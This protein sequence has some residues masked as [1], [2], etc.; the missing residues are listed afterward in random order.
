[1][2]EKIIFLDF[3]GPLTNARVILG[4]GD[5]YGFDPVA[6]QAPNNICATTGIRI[7][8]SSSRTH[9]SSESN[10]QETMALFASHGFDV[11]HFHDD[12]SCSR[13]IRSKRKADI[14]EWLKKH[15]EVTHYAIVDDDA[16]RMPN[17][18]R[19]NEAEGMLLRHFSKMA[20]ILDFNLAA[21]FARAH[22]N[23][24]ESKAN[25]S[26]VKFPAIKPD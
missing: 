5:E 26:G 23:H 15:P 16:V 4:S 17:L 11:S 2:C 13:G 3:D 6:V 9:A 22:E 18:I 25:V 10:R 12:W 14:Q 1:M 24:Y 7:V 21:V 8:C 19:V 20:K